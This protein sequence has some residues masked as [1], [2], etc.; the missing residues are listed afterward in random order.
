MPAKLDLLYDRLN[1]DDISE[2]LASKL[3]EIAKSMENRRLDEAYPFRASSGAHLQF[4]YV[5]QADLFFRPL[6]VHSPELYSQHGF[7]WSPAS[8]RSSFPCLLPPCPTSI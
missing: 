4:Y 8:D 6:L 1:S 3:R 2:D 5:Y 7:R